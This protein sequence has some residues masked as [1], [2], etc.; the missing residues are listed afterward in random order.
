MKHILKIAKSLYALVLSMVLLIY[1]ST[2][3]FAADNAIDTKEE[4]SAA[5]ARINA[6]YGT[7]IRILSENKLAQYDLIVAEPQV[8]IVK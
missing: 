1:M 4:I 8:L 3:A 2:V 5:F 6:E 7:N